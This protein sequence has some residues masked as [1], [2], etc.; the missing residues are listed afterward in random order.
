MTGITPPS[1]AGGGGRGGDINQPF[2]VHK[3][4]CFHGVLPDGAKKPQ[5]HVEAEEWVKRLE[6]DAIAFGWN[7]VQ[8]AHRAVSL[9]RGQAERWFGWLA[10]EKVHKF[11]EV[12]DNWPALKHLIVKKYFKVSR[13]EQASADW[14]TAKQGP[15]PAWVYMSDLRMKA[16][17]SLNMLRPANFDD[18]YR[19]FEPEDPPQ[20]FVQHASKY[21]EVMGADQD[22][23]DDFSDSCYEWIQK[24]MERPMRGAERCGYLNYLG[25]EMQRVVLDGLHDERIKIRVQELF[26]ADTDYMD[27]CD[28]IQIDEQNM[29]LR[30]SKPKGRS[31]VSAVSKGDS[32][33]GGEQVEAAKALSKNQKKKM[34]K[35]E[36]KEAAETQVEEVRDTRT[37][38]NCGKQGHISPNC[39]QP[40]KERGATGVKPPGKSTRKPARYGKGSSTNI[41]T[42]AV[43]PGDIYVHDDGEESVWNGSEWTAPEN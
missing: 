5:D 43:F 39:T 38:Y 1:V 28:L 24:C 20:R 14:Q 12:R 9:L 16:M 10:S 30:G 2:T 3:D 34:K 8:T 29:Q 25:Q 19:E 32:E 22:F 42:A 36:K 37:C 4:Y 21:F 23:K 26:K 18:V 11:R 6:K 31:G 27:V 17:T 35:K 7:H 41:Q 13:I 33:D 15:W 40:R